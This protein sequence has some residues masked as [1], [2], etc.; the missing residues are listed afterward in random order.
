MNTENQTTDN[1]TS[2]NQN[3]SE[4]AR[5][6]FLAGVG[7]AALAHEETEAFI[8][9]LIEKGEIAEN[10]GVTILKNLRNKRRKRVE[11]AL[12]KR[13]SIILERLDIPTQSDYETLTKKITELTQKLDEI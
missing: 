6:I 3:F 2:D 12:D 5:K 8:K 10:D 4:L 7:A 1:K 13:I 11:D 9:R